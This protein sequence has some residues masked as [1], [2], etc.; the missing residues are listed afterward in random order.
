MLRAPARGTR[1]AHPFRNLDRAFRG[2]HWEATTPLVTVRPM[3]P[4]GLRRGLAVVAT[5]GLLGAGPSASAGH[6]R[7]SYI[8]RC[9]LINVETGARTCTYTFVHTRDVETFVVPP[10]KVPIEITAVGAPGFGED[11]VRS[12]G[13]RV[14]GSFP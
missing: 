12:H 3:T 4:G 6:D 5:C 9:G 2:G 14:S 10:T 8:T 7:P 1:R 13:A 11:T